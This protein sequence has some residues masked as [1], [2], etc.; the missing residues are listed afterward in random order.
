MIQCII[1]NESVGTTCDRRCRSEDDITVTVKE[2][3]R[4]LYP[5]QI[6]QA[7]WR[8]RES[9]A[10]VPRFEPREEPKVKMIQCII[11]KESVGTTCD[12]RYRSEDDITVT[13]KENLRHLHHN[14]WTLYAPLIFYV[15]LFFLTNVCATTLIY[16]PSFI[17]REN[18]IIFSNALSLNRRIPTG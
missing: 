5:D 7:K 2:N 1:F 18:E 17:L 13:V 8:W 16:V 11:F 15:F 3:L 10:T 9:K 12:R 14:K 6:I 4:H